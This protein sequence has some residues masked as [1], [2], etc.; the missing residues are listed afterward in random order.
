MM[1]LIAPKRTLVIMR[2]CGFV[3]Q[4][5]LRMRL[6]QVQGAGA[7][8]VCLAVAALHLSPHSAVLPAIPGD[9]HGGVRAKARL[10]T[11][12]WPGFRPVG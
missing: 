6:D 2:P 4:L 7:S 5:R 12:R 8:Q 10:G 9:R 3:R 1:Q 11:H